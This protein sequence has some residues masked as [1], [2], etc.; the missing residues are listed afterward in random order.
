MAPR[1]LIAMVRPSKPIAE[2]TNGKRFA[3]E[4]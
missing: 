2:M 4:H 3:A 1:K